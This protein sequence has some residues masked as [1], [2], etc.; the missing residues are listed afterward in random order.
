MQKVKKD[1]YNFLIN[2]EFFSSKSTKKNDSKKNNS[3]K[4]FSELIVKKNRRKKMMLTI[5]VWG[6]SYCGKSMLIHFGLCLA[7]LI[8]LRNI[9]IRTAI[10]MIQLRPSIREPKAEPKSD[11]DWKGNLLLLKQIFVWGET[12]LWKIGK[13]MLGRSIKLDTGASCLNNFQ[14]S[15]G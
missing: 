2:L 11:P 15:C 10:Q 6:E 14:R 8:P 5:V 13:N 3:K 12:P 7:S 9:V 4:T 1:W